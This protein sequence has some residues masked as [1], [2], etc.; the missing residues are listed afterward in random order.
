MRQLFLLLFLLACKTFISQAEFDYR[1]F[2]QKMCS[3]DFHG[4]GYVS[5]GDSIAAEYIA[6]NMIELGIDSLPFGYFQSFNL[7][8]NAFPDYC[9]V[10]LGG[11]D[12][13]PGIDYVFMPFSHGNCI[14]N[15][16]DKMLKYNIIR[17][18]GKEILAQP[19][20]IL[21][22]VTSNQ[23]LLVDN[24]GY[25][26][27]SSRQIESFLKELCHLGVPIAEIVDH[28]FTWSLS[29]YQTSEFYI[30]IKASNLNVPD[31]T[32]DI[33][34]RSNLIYNYQSRNV[35][36]TIPAKKKSKG[37]IMLT[38]HYDHLGRMGSA[39]Y[40]PGANDNASGVAMLL[41]LGHMIGNRPLR[42]YDVILVAFAGEE[43]GL[44]GSKH[45][46][47]T[48]IIDL[49]RVKFLL[50]L[51]IMGSGEEGITA[52]NGRVFSKEF[53]RLQ[54][55]NQKLKAVPIVK[56]RGKSANSDHHFFTEKGVRSFFIYTMGENKN[57]H[58]VYDTYENLSFSSFEKLSDLFYI[59]LR[60]I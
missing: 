57:Y 39:T 56:A 60:K 7:D 15:E 44:L 35:I 5:Q 20:K 49:N 14:N 8:V 28:K 31:S 6:K 43:I 45:M 48:D 52:V 41:Q 30:Q 13:R 59:F 42:K 2:T 55:L 9:K 4:R 47:E 10:N 58:D 24:T 32:I 27:D 21:N 26:A 46:S 3:S 17:K 51:D 50:N 16:C 11:K 40:F 19:K 23:I 38:A 37:T 22:E 33:L 29:P 18:A 34:L 54:K 53:K 12:L 36:G 1:G 25:S